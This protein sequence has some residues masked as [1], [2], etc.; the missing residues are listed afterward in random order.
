MKKCYLLHAILLMPLASFAQPANDDCA[1]AQV[2]SISNSI[3]TV[4]F[5]INTAVISNQLICNSTS[6][7]ADVWYK[8]TMPYNG[9][10]NIDS[11][12][13]INNFALYDAC[14]GNEIL[15]INLRGL[16]PNLTTNS[17]YLLRLFRTASNASDPANQSF[18]IQGFQEVTNDDCSTAQT[19]TVSTNSTTV[20]F[21]I[22]GAHINNEVGCEGST[23]KTHADV[24]YDFTMPINGDI[25]I[26]SGFSINNFALY[27]ACNGLQIG[28]SITNG[29]FQNL[30]SGSTYKLRMYRLSSNAY[31]PLFK[32]FNISVDSALGISDKS[33]ND[34]KIYPNPAIETINI[35]S[36][37][38]YEKIEM[39]DILGHQIKTV[40]NTNEINVSK[41]SEG[42]YIL[43]IY[44]PKGFVSKQMIK[45]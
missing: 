43:K 25:K 23:P 15:C 16:L 30:T 29:L 27:D 18:T 24:W 34:I 14:G 37:F 13:G 2:L 28:C 40:Y 31:Y 33:Q 26:S 44:T 35:S 10:V 42:V 17:V 19:I 6:N 12:N 41:L 22:G 38:P 3:I 11:G 36:A 45:K 8:F 7:Y 32:S 5:D 39:Y 20:N 1:N 4:P 9:N 21:E